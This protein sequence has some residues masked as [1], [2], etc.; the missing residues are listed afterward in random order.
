MSSMGLEEMASSN[1]AIELMIKNKDAIFAKD[2]FDQALEPVY[3]S[4][5]KYSFYFVFF[6]FCFLLLLL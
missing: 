1:R 5:L 6:G 4:D 2:H 3:D